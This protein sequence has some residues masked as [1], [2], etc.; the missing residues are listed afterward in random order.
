MTQSEAVSGRRTRR[1]RTRRMR[2]RRY[3]GQEGGFLDA[4]Q[5]HNLSALWLIVRLRWPRSY[6]SCG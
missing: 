2:R 3:G 5:S 1:K 6:L 4:S